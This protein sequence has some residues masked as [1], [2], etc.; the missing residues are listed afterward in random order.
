[1]CIIYL[2]FTRKVLVFALHIWKHAVKS[3]KLNGNGRSETTEFVRYC[4]SAEPRIFSVTNQRRHAK[5]H[6][7]RQRGCKK[8]REVGV[9]SWILWRILLLS[10]ITVIFNLSD[11]QA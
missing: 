4:A 11:S 7:Q 5:R 9:C 6:R 3:S 1:M 10:V 2:F 8:R